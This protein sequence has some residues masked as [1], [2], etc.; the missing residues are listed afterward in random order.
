MCDNGGE[1]YFLDIFEDGRGAMGT[2]IS[3]S[4]ETVEIFQLLLLLSRMQFQSFRWPCC[5]KEHCFEVCRDPSNTYANS[6]E[7]MHWRRL[8]MTALQNPTPVLMSLHASHALS[9]THTDEDKVWEVFL[10]KLSLHRDL[11]SSINKTQLT[12]WPFL[13]NNSYWHVP[14]VPINQQQTEIS[15][16]SQQLIFWLLCIHQQITLGSWHYTSQK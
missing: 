10:M 13:L 2:T 14:F 12:L 7:R 3:E 16:S 6:N 1:K 15:E 8:W 4:K 5:D 9:L 11:D